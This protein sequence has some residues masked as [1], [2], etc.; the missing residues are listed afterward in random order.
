MRFK[1]IFGWFGAVFE[2]GAAKMEKSRAAKSEVVPQKK[3]LRKQK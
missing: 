2:S 1:E 3:A